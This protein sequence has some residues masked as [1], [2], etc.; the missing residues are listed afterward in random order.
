MKIP[1]RR[2]DAQE[3]ALVALDG[4]TLV[5]DRITP[6]DPPAPRPRPRLTAAMLTNA[7]LTTDVGWT[8]WGGVRNPQDLQKRLRAAYRYHLIQQAV[9]RIALLVG[10]AQLITVDGPKDDPVRVERPSLEPLLKLLA[11]P[12]L[13]GEWGSDLRVLG[14]SFGYKHGWRET[15]GREVWAVERLHPL[16]VEVV[17]LPEPGTGRLFI[18][19]YRLAPSSFAYRY[20]SP[21]YASVSSFA[22]GGGVSERPI[23]NPP[24]L[25]EF[26]PDEIIHLR[27]FQDRTRL[28]GRCDLETALDLIRED[29]QRGQY[30]TTLFENTAA[31][32]GFLTPADKESDITEEDMEAEAALFQAAAQGVRRGSIGVLNRAMKFEGTAISPKDM[33]L[34]HEDERQ[35][36]R[37][38]SH[39]GLSAAQ[40]GWPVGLRNQRWGRYQTEMIAELANLRTLWGMLATQLT[41]Q[42]LDAWP[43]TAAIGLR[44]GW[45]YSEVEA[46]REVDAENAMREE[47]R[48]EVEARRLVLA[49]RA[50][51]ATG[52]DIAAAFGLEYGDDQ[53]RGDLL[54]VWERLVRLGLVSREV[55]ADVLGLPEPPVVAPAGA[56]ATVLAD[57][58]L[59]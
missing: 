54:P 45:D 56:G 55:A 17:I 20:A 39:F 25:G 7:E 58:E 57:E 1:F 19:G 36:A 10:S 3:A 52:A 18:Q 40:L 50:G 49:K 47:Q 4:G 30:A 11:D 43:D 9:N 48:K 14:N 42:V 51:G 5:P 21:L 53:R 12:T 16:D 35:E 31:M 37:L 8:G 2:A 6:P 26:T 27:Y 23:S 44:F 59:I 29:F 38:A 24:A 28:L 13:M 41:T 46:I 33:M 34:E 32:P 22:L 15:E